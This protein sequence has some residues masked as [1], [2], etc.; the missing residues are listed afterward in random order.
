[1]LPVLF[2]CL[3]YRVVLLLYLLFLYYINYIFIFA[4]IFVY[5]LEV[6]NSFIISGMCLCKRCLYQA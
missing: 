5:F 4:E 6:V 3:F 1:M 2:L